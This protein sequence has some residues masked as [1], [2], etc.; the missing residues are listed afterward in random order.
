MP[1]ISMCTQ[2]LC[3]NAES[4]YRFKAKPSE[5]QS[6]SQ[7]EYTIDADGV[8]CEYY[9]PMPENDRGV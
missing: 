5:L 4:C 2:R 1:D 9:W 7:F 6:Y 3:P 8:N